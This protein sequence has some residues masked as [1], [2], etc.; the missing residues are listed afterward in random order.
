MDAGSFVIVSGRRKERL[1][2]FVK[3]YGVTR[4]Q[5]LHFDITKLDTIP[6]T[7]SAITKE[8]EGLD[9]VFI[10]S[11]I[12]RGADF[13][14][15]DGIDMDLI[16]QELTVNYL[17]PLTLTKAFLPFLQAKN[18]KTVLIYTTSGL[19]LVPAV[20]CPNYC[21]AKA[22]MHHFLLCL[23]EQLKDTHVKVVEL[24]P[25]AVQTELH[26][27]KNQPDLKGGRFGMPLDEFTNEAFRGLAQGLDQIPVGVA[28]LSFEGWERERQKAF[29]GMV[30]RMGGQPSE[31]LKS[32]V[33]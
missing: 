14:R 17:G 9:C 26:D 25:P 16:N 28:K 22:A 29:A 1:D 7:V 2:A 20:R 15:P 33:G 23:R 30:V 32:F 5:A 21:A 6:E 10:N 19:S 12:Q 18:S 27:E 8:H 4:A 13:S 11:G 24:I 3:E 31:S